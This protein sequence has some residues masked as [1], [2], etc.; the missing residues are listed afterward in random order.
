METETKQTEEELD[1]E[2]LQQLVLEA[3]QEVLANPAT[4][5]RKKKRSIPK[6]FIWVMSIILITQSFAFIFQLYSIPAIAFLKTSAQLSLNED[7]RELKKAVVVVS[8][9]N[10]KGTGF[11][12]R[13]DGWIITNDH[14]VDNNERVHVLFPEEG[15]FEATVVQRYPINDVAILRVDGDHLPALSFATTPPKKGDIIRFIGNPLSFNGIVNEGHVLEPIVLDGWPHEVMMMKAPV[16]RGNSGS[17]V[18][19]EQN[20]VIGVIFATLQHD[21]YGIVGLYIPIQEVHQ[22]LENE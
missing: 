22:L 2:T 15:R 3:Q 21:D 16:Y 9:G 4:N 14:V 7:I 20:D 19:N 18:F 11:S 6:W 10:S 17:P 13:S 5:E 8:A 1:D 12:F